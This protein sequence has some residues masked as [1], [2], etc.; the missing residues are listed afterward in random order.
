MFTFDQKRLI[1]FLNDAK[2]S[3]FFNDYLVWSTLSNICEVIRKK[4][5]E[6]V[7]P[8][9]GGRGNL[10]STAP[11]S[12]SLIDRAWAKSYNCFHYSE[13]LVL[14]T[15]VTYKYKWKDLEFVHYLFHQWT[16]EKVITLNRKKELYGIAYQARSISLK[17]LK[18]TIAILNKERI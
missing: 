4:H 9:Q 7:L 16:S 8:A 3:I 13:L 12:Q 5:E 15:S 14:Q 1:L 2:L 17:I 10:L 18:R 6:L 11:R